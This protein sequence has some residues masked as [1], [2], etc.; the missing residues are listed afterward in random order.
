MSLMADQELRKSLL[1]KAFFHENPETWQLLMSKAPLDME[2][3]MDPA[4]P[5]KSVVAE[6]PPAVYRNA[7]ACQDA[8]EQRRLMERE[9]LAA[10]QRNGQLLLFPQTQVLEPLRPSAFEV[11]RDT[12]RDAQEAE[13]TRL[14][15]EFTK[16]AARAT[17]LRQ[18]FTMQAGRQRLLQRQL[19]VCRK[20]MERADCE[21]FCMTADLALQGFRG[22]LP[23]L[24]AEVDALAEEELAAYGKEGESLQEANPAAESW[25]QKLA[26]R[27]GRST[28]PWWTIPR[29]VTSTVPSS[30]WLRSAP[31]VAKAIMTAF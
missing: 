26:A 7:A 9:R 3:A 16:D 15:D 31:R 11:V 8:M 28:S 10:Q 5:G 4:T 18:Q 22:L 29:S 2:P 12:G 6:A 25:L 30:T 20:P 24:R 19:D 14:Y 23:K 1:L 17:A 13:F 27:C 21:R